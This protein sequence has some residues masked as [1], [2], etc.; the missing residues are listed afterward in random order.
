[1]TGRILWVV[2]ACALATV[3]VS[4]ALGHGGGLDRHG[5]HRET[6]TGGYHCH[7]SKDEGKEA[8]KYIGIAAG[9]ALAGV[10]IWYWLDCEE[11]PVR[12]SLNLHLG[13]EMR[14]D[15]DRGGHYY[16]VSWKVMF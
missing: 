7:R 15:R 3:P 6:A 12:R 5:C 2:L 10:A 8:L 11:E 13:P 1:M 4:G 16:G 9:A 14:D